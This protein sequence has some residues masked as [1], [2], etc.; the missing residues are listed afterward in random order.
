MKI[1]QRLIL[2]FILVIGGMGCSSVK[3]LWQAGRGQVGLSNRAVLISDYLKKDGVSPRTRVLLES[4]AEI[5]KF[6]EDQGLETTPN[7][8]RYVPLDRPYVVYTVTACAPLKFEP[9]IWEFPFV[10]SVPY[11]GWFHEED[12]KKF[13][14]TLK[15]E[16]L[17]VSVRGVRAFST[18]GWFQDPVLSSMILEGTHA[19][20]YLAEV[21]LHESVH[22]TFYIPAQT[23]FNESLASFVGDRLAEEFL[24]KKFGPE[25]EE[26]LSWSHSQKKSEKLEEN[27]HKAYLDLEKIYSSSSSDSEK[28]TQKQEILK[29]LEAAS[30]YGQSLN[31]ANMMQFKTYQT[32]IPELEKLWER[33]GKNWVKFWEAIRKIKTGHFPHQQEEDLSS[34]IRPLLG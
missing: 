24:L 34:V 15:Q 1:I 17:D 14:E 12:A 10:G 26:Y 27:F 20:G 5:K 25:S 30:A 8:L 22:A 2:T 29:K 6:G 21:I 23:P 4:I 9:K 33:S 11:L 16:G 32:G 28:S 3:Y 19:Q 18:L 31:N 13:A 7:Y